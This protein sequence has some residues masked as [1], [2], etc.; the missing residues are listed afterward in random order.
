MT[1]F[2]HHVNTT[3]SHCV[4]VIICIRSLLDILKSAIYLGD[5][6]RKCLIYSYVNF[7]RLKTY[8]TT[9]V[10]HLSADTHLPWYWGLG[11]CHDK[12]YQSALKTLRCR[13]YGNDMAGNRSTM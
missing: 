3:V 2:R 11:R 8:E 12:S 6:H 5:W 7:W 4:K 10:G 1:D 13:F 9:C